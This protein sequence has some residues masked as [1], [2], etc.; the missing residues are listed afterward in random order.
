[1][2]T[3]IMQRLLGI[4]WPPAPPGEVHPEDFVRPP[5]AAFDQPMAEAIQAAPDNPAP[6]RVYGTWLAEQNDPRGPLI[7]AMLDGA[8]AVIEPF[9][10]NFMGPL[11]GEAGV[12]VTW[13]WGFWDTLV[14]DDPWGE[15]VALLL[16]KALAHPSALV[17]R[18]LTVNTGRMEQVADLLADGPQLGLRVLT[19]NAEGSLLGAWAAVWSRVPRLRSLTLLG[20]GVQI[21]DL[22]LPEL[23]Q[24]EIRGPVPDA[25]MNDLRRAHLPKLQRLAVPRPDGLRDVFGERVAES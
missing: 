19:V 14:I 17:L 11:D 3:W 18:E 7:L 22:S 10:P 21:G 5:N 9:A 4:Q 13:R 8:D 15:K 2:L 25:S 24:L 6:Y 20:S 16:K 12:S 23:E 1:M